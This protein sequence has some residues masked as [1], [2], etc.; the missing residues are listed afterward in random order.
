MV[1][2]YMIMRDNTD[3]VLEHVYVEYSTFTAGNQPF[4]SIVICKLGYAARTQV[5]MQNKAG[6]MERREK[7]R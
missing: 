7:E 1:D 2:D 4:Y 5:K 3:N 6:I